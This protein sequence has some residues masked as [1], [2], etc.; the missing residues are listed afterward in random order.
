M[1]AVE[2]SPFHV[3]ISDWNAEPMDILLLMYRDTGLVPWC[4][5]SVVLNGKSRTRCHSPEEIEASGGPGRN[6]LG[7]LVQ[8]KQDLF[9]NEQVCEETFTPL[10]VFEAR[11]GQEWVWIN[12]I[13]SGAHHEL[14]ISVDHHEFYVVAA[15]GEF[16]HPQK[17]HAANCNLGERIRSVS[18]SSLAPRANRLELMKVGGL[19]SHSILIHLN[20]KP[21][22]Y[23]I[24]VT[25]LRREQIIQGVGILRYPGLKRAELSDFPDTE[26]WV[27]LNGS[28]VTDSLTAMQETTLRPFPARPPP[29]RADHTLKFRVEMTGP[30]SWALNIAPHEGFRQQLPP[31]MWDES[32]RGRTSYGGGGGCA[33]EGMHNCSSTGGGRGTLSNGSVVDIV[34]ENGAN[35]IT[36]HPF[37]K[38][39]HKAW[40]I[41]TGS[42]GFPWAS[43]DEAIQKGGPSVEERFNFVDPP[44]RDGCRLGN[45]TGDWTAVRYE[46]F[47][48][49]VSMLHCHMIHHFAVSAH[50]Q[51]VV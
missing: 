37:H 30:S 42:G 26:P 33:D 21:Q 20:Q 5:N 6:T 12:F 51:M 11:E 18:A 9:A 35:V 19:T 38:H 4:S 15:D 47:F 17:V 27:H 24:R 14:Q 7:C 10:E 23:A 2:A 28:L 46:I 36:Q 29:P 1:R 40:I 50:M 43:V 3:V 49:A 16:V 34:F 31:L 45:Q 8:E 39:N 32:S 44:L 41:G 22:D 13:H 48:P 25:S